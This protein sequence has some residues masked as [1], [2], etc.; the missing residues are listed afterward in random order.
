MFEGDY[1]GNIFYYE[2]ILAIFIILLGWKYIF[3]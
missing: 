1:F 2:K 3:L